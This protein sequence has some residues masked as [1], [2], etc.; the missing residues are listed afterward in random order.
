MDE[1]AIYL[2]RHGAAD[3]HWGQSA[4]PGLSALG[5]EQAE[6]C[7]SALAPRLETSALL[8]SSPL[9]RARQTAVPLAQRLQRE[10]HI[11]EAFR[12]V[13][14]PVPLAQRRDWLRA[15]M[16]ETWDD[17]PEALLGWR[18]AALDA[19]RDLQAP[20]VIFTHFL[21][22]NAVVGHLRGDNSTLCFWPDNASISEL[23]IR[24]GEL[25]LTALGRE[26]ETVVN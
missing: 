23:A 26:M 15:F 24:D 14:A 25:S 12:E 1:V 11:H 20:C 18:A 17:Q 10:V 6:A 22:I 4:D 19:L 5:R 9:A 8:I 7:A 13:P 2:V 3:A 21:V 16:R